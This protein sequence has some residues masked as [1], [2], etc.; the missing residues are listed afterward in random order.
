[1]ETTNIINNKEKFILLAEGNTSALTNFLPEV[2][3][4]AK[5]ALNTLE[6]PTT[7]NEE[8]RYTRTT[9][10][11]NEDWTY[12]AP[13][14]HNSVLVPQIEDHNASQIV[15][16]NGVF[17][18]ELSNIKEEKGVGVS[19]EQPSSSAFFAKF[20]IP[21]PANFFEAFQRSTSSALLTIHVSKNHVAE[22]PIHIV[23]ICNAENIIATPSIFVLLE[24]SAA[25]DITESFHGVDSSKSLTIRGLYAQIEENARL[26]YNKIQVESDAQYAIHSDLIRVETNGYSNFNTLTID[27]G[28]IRNDLRIDLNGQNIETHLSGFYL[29]RRK[30]LIDNHTKVDHLFPHCESNELYKGIL[31]DQSSGVFNGKVF[32]RKDAQKTN[33][34]QTN[35]NILASDDAQMNSKPEL[36]IYADD[37][38]CSHGS[39]TGQI[40]DEAMFYLRARGMSQDNARKLL[41]TAFINDVIEK[42]SNKAVKQHVLMALA[43]KG[44]LY[45]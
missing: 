17:N 13:A 15:F 33:A 35:A 10:L 18:S 38:K 5:E 4:A 43:D 37:V 40:D 45:I 26:E 22:T 19:T 36:E 8:W 41:T 44:L 27:G 21:S 11:A 7:R 1:M 25:I 2:V 20:N 23:H 16:V 9:K 12:A 34:Y 6:L 31:F 14:E 3:T 29:P 30:Q 24:N 39:T 28:W 32:V 42:V